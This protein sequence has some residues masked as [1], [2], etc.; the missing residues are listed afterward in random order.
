[1][2]VSSCWISHY[3]IH[4]VRGA[5]NK[6]A[7]QTCSEPIA[8]IPTHHISQGRLLQPSTGPVPPS[9]TCSTLRNEPVALGQ[10]RVNS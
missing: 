1:M 5:T 3:G 8:V 6:I 10:R 9:S 2:G 4:G 7:A